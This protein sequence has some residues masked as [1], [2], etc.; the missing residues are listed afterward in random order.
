MQF[1][2]YYYRENNSK[3]KSIFFKGFTVFCAIVFLFVLITIA[4]CGDHLSLEPSTIEEYEKKLFEES[5][6]SSTVDSDIWQ[7]AAWVEHGGKTGPERC[8]SANGNLN[9]IFINN[10]VL[11]YLSSAIQTRKEYR[12]GRW[13][14][15]LKPSSVPGI[16][17]AMY[18]IDWNDTSQAGSD[19]DGTKQEIDIEF[20]TYTFGRGKGS[21]HFAVHEQ[22]KT[23]FDTNPDVPLDFDP[24][25]DFHVW[26]FEISPTRIRWFVD[27]SI[28]LTYY[29][30]GNPIAITA[31][32][33]LKFSSWSSETWVNGP[34]ASGVECSFLIDW[35]KFI[36]Y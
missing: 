34:P 2:I 33:Q 8:Y 24:S 30:E 23:S 5:F 32:Y 21:V 17:N 22:G 20:L 29:Y 1:T 25:D 19:S 11:G 12:Y 9:M 3:F 28:L 35:V 7:V 36:P 27:E 6:D 26:G 15:R 13:E 14:A 10:S 16:C 4:A 18:T 31:P